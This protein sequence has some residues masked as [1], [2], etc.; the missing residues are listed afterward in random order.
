MLGEPDAAVVDALLGFPSTIM[1]RVRRKAAPDRRAALD[2]Q[3]AVAVEL[4][5]MAPIRLGNLVAIDIGI[6]F[7]HSKPDEGVCTWSF[8][9]R[10]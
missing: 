3:I 8:P 1:S 6:C 4:V 9:W 5:T 10:K 2:V 7:G